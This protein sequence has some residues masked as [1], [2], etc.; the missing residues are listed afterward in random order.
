M[1]DNML[2]LGCLDLQSPQS[3]IARRRS[4][5]TRNRIFIDRAR[6]L[7]VNYYFSG[8]LQD[9]PLRRCAPAPPLLRAATFAPDF[10]SKILLYL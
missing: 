4:S 2:L 7:Q 6:A 8:I 1:C 3:Y 9:N 5:V 10:S